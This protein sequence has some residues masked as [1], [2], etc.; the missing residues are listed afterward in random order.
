MTKTIMQQYEIVRSSGACNMWN[1]GCVI[2]TA[3]KL[4]CIK[5]SE[6]TK[7][8]YMDILQNFCKYMKQFD[9]KQ[10]SWARH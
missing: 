5:L 2:S 1:Y 7:D 3:K 4:D 8:E 9:I 10:K 6:V